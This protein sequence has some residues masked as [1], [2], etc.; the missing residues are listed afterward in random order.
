MDKRPLVSF[1]FT[2]YKR[3]DILIETIR[4]IMVQSIGDW[5]V[6]V[7]DNDPDQSGRKIE[8]AFDD[9]RIRY[10][11]NGENLGMKKSFNKSLDRSRGSF[12][13]MIADDDPVYPD[14]LETLFKLERQYPGYG[15]YMG[16]G[17]L[18]CMTVSLAELNGLRIGTNTFLN[19]EHDE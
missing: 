8:S 5:E 19:N 17:D 16:G 18:Y 11:P 2:T 15:M 14:M 6:V 1:C 3:P 9:E 7:S 10:F 4:S 12:I 13:V